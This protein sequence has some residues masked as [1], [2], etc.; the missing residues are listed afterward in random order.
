MKKY[1]FILIFSCKYASAIQ[2]LSICEFQ[3]KYIPLK[4]MIQV[5]K[6]KKF[7]Y[8][9]NSTNHVMQMFYNLNSVD[10]KKLIDECDDNKSRFQSCIILSKAAI[11]AHFQKAKKGSDASL[12]VVSLLYY[13]RQFDQFF[14]QQE[15]KKTY[16]ECFSNGLPVSTLKCEKEIKVIGEYIEI[17]HA[18]IKIFISKHNNENKSNQIIE[19]IINKNNLEEIAE[20]LYQQCRKPI[21]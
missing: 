6:M 3:K 15:M 12:L 16:L 10:F 1:F 9:M 19:Y 4:E 8:S 18:F 5:I 20:K 11:N 2:Y 13:L 14:F 17:F 7:D 21:I